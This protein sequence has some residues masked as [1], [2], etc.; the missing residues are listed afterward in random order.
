MYPTAVVCIL[1]AGSGFV[2]RVVGLN[3]I[4]CECPGKEVKWCN[5][6]GKSGQT[7][8]LSLATFYPGSPKLQFKKDEGIPSC[9]NS[10]S[11]IPFFQDQ[12]E[13]FFQHV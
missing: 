4:V 9:W 6:P 3:R 5:V 11:L 1:L 10:V 13:E 7:I 12:H 8:G 2:G